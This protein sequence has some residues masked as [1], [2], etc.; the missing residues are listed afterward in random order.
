MIVLIGATVRVLE[1]AFLGIGTDPY[2]SEPQMRAPTT[3]VH[4][5]VRERASCGYMKSK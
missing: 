5:Y 4:T 2:V 3:R 1:Y